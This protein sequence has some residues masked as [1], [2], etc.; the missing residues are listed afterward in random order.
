M[1]PD[2]AE[3]PV[4]RLVDEF[5]T[6]LDEAL[7]VAIASDYSLVESAGFDA[8]R[9]TL[10]GLAQN[11]PSE[12]ASGFNASGI[13]ICDGASDAPK[14]D[15][16]TSASGSHPSSRTH[17]TE[18]SS[19]DTCTSSTAEEQLAGIPRLSSFDGDT[20]ESKV[21]VLQSMFAELSEYDIKHSLKK[22][23]EDFQVALDN[24]LNVQYLRSTGQD[25]KGIEAFLQPDNAPQQH[26]KRWKKKKRNANRSS[27]PDV[28]VSPEEALDDVTCQYEIEYIAERFGIRSDEVSGVYSK[29]QHSAGA[30]VVELLDLYLSHGIETKDETG[31]EH[32]D[33][34]A[35]KY[36]HVP[37]KYM[38]TIV[39]VA[40]SIPQFAED[41]AS[42][43]SK[44]FARQSKG[45]KLDLSYR[46]T[47]LPKDEIEGM[48]QLAIG[49]S[50]RRLVSSRS[51]A[52]PALTTGNAD[53][54][55]ALQQANQLHQAKRDTL[56]TAAQLQRR[57]G[58][59]PLYRQ[60]ATFYTDRGRDLG[61]RAQLATSNAADLLVHQ[62]STPHSIDLHGV[63]V[64]DGVRIALQKT[65][66]WWNGLGEFRARK[67]KEQGFTVITGLGRHSAGGVSHLRQAVAA[68][69]L[70]D[71]WRLQVDTG[72]FLI[73]GRR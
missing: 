30:T 1:T 70:Q 6:L 27:P 54:A 52:L 3:D 55:Q 39:H 60:A 47:P 68:A 45:H 51:V 65:Q 29:N 57:G 24:L 8:A 26:G 34:L 13:P 44:H 42:L 20:H 5:H 16:T 38:P 28:G 36:R 56:S 4:Q 33:G 35:K 61:R 32:A 11:V 41:L 72:K 69:L 37:S 22:A 17:A 58:S 67:A 62:Q 2:G 43:L 40:G 73:T 19:A 46:L 50:A 15:C 12:E 21:L 49:G 18:S 9:S 53:L 14:G 23:N 64:Q 63:F 59:S 7:I 48:E 25:A 10:Q 31:K 71:G 66:E